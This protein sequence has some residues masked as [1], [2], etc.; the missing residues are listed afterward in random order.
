MHRSDK[1]LE[2]IYAA[3]TRYIL[4]KWREFVEVEDEKILSNENEVHIHLAPAFVTLYDRII[5]RQISDA[6]E[7]DDRDILQLMDN[8]YRFGEYCAANGFYEY[9][10]FT[11]CACTHIT[12]K[13]M[14]FLQHGTD[15]A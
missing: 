2:E 5:S 15:Y 3:E 4:N 10:Q 9:Q 7:I 1:V 13:D 14:S 12:D 8:M 6:E 11:K